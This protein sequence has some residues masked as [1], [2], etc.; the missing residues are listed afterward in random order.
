MVLKSIIARLFCNWINNNLPF[1][2]KGNN[3]RI[4]GYP[5]YCLNP[6]V[7]L[8]NNVQI[9]P[10][11]TFAGNSN[12]TIGNN[13]KIGNNVMINASSKEGIFIGDGTIIAANTYIID[14]NHGIAKGEPIQNQP[15][16]SAA[17]CVGRNVW[18]AAN[19][20]IA[21]GAAI[22]D[23]AV[24]GAGSFLNGT[25]GEEE[26]FAGSPARFIKNRK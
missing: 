3:L 12:I 26:V 2:Q 24:I 14:S 21:K 25:V 8:G 22:G 23:G 4:I 6:N 17:I 9:Y 19:C 13:V 16:D 20:V 5:Y 10:G 1:L 18:I 7:K 11:V 15:L